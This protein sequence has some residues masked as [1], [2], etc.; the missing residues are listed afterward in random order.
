MEF[1][2]EG[3][4]KFINMVIQEVLKGIEQFYLDRIN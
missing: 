1:R 4:F 3:K 2:L